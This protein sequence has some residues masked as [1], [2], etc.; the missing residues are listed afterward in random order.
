[1][2]LWLAWTAGGVAFVLT[3]YGAALGLYGWHVMHSDFIQDLKR[4]SAAYG[5]IGAVHDPKRPRARAAVWVARHY[6]GFGKGPPP[7]SRSLKELVTYWVVDW[8]TSPA[9]ANRMY[10]ALPHRRFDGFDGVARAFSGK[11]YCAL[12]PAR[13]QAVLDYYWGGRR[14]RLEQA[15]RG[16]PL[17]DTPR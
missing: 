6:M 8:S 13:R 11:S 15:M 1:V 14:D 5:C 17:P 12:D 3:F 4:R 16:E 2:K 9:E 10:A 7:I